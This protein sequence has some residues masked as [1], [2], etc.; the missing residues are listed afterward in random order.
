MSS[1]HDHRSLEALSR[2]ECLRL[3]AEHPARVGRVAPAAERPDILPVNYVVDDDGAVVFRTEEGKKL[4]AAARGKFVAFEVD[5]VDPGWRT[6]WSVLIRG[7]AQEITD[8]DDLA[9]VRQLPLDSWAPGTKG[10]YVRITPEIISGRR[11]G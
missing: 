7:W 5:T 9:R 10:H 3:L 2:D 4:D 6:G 11:L 1:D 8:P